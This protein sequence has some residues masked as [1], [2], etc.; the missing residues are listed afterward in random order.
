M[1]G[2]GYPDADFLGGLDPKLAEIRATLPDQTFEVD[3][4]AGDLTR[5]WADKLGLPAGIPVAIGRL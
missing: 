3:Q 1:S 4:K 2:A 5:A